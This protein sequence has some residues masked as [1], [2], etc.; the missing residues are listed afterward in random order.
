MGNMCGLS[1]T[2]GHLPKALPVTEQPPQGDLPPA[3]AETEP[4]AA[5]A[6]DLRHALKGAQGGEKRHFVLQG[7]WWKGVLERYFQE[8]ISLSQSLHLLTSGKAL[9]IFMVK[10]SSSWLAENLV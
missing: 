2:N 10:F 7:N 1:T 3:S 8:V 4:C 5:A 6:V 9:N